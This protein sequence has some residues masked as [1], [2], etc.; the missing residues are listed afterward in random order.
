M[1]KEDQRRTRPTSK[2]LRQPEQRNAPQRLLS[3][4]WNPFQL[5]YGHLLL[6]GAVICRQA[7]RFHFDEKMVVSKNS[8]Q[9]SEFSKKKKN[10]GQHEPESGGREPRGQAPAAAVDD[11]EYKLTILS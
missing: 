1:K 2:A 11:F 3:D 10:H 6:H 4:L 5:L 9:N 7:L 8:I